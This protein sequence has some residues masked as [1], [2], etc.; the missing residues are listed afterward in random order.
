MALVSTWPGGGLEAT[1][2]S[3][4]LTLHSLD[5]QC[6]CKGPVLTMTL[7]HFLDIRN[8]GVPSPTHPA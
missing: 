5:P 2:L 3:V 4:T 6:P 7:G 8:L 1:A